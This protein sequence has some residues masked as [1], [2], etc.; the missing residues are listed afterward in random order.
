M[1][2][3]GNKV[4][5]VAAGGAAAAVGAALAATAAAGTASADDLIGSAYYWPEQQQNTDVSMGDPW[6]FRGPTNYHVQTQPACWLYPN[7]DDLVAEVQVTAPDRFEPFPFDVDRLF[8]PVRNTVTVDWT[9]TT[10]GDQ[11]RTVTHGDSMSVL[12]GVPG[13]P[14]RIEMDIHLRAD[15]PW[16]SDIGSTDLPVGHATADTH[17]VVDL[18]GKSCA[19]S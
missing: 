4:Q 18:A 7:H 12:S 16:L 11:G 5:R 3:F 2:S 19:P 9:N 10:T 13:G 15:H 6:V 17:A 14:G 1:G 8:F